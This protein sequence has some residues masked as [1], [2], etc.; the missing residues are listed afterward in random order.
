MQTVSAC[1]AKVQHHGNRLAPRR[2]GIR[3]CRPIAQP[4]DAADNVAYRVGPSAV[5]ASDPQRDDRR[6]AQLPPTAEMSTLTGGCAS[7]RRQ[8]VLAEPA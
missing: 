4:A 8:E 5:L 7:C 1:L 6:R 3:S 2:R